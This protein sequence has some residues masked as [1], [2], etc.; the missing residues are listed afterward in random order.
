MLSGSVETTSKVV[1]ASGTVATGIQAPPSKGWYQP[2]SEFTSYSQVPWYRKR[3]VL[4][5][6]II[7]IVFLPVASLLAFS[8]DVYFTKKGQVVK[9]SKGYRVFIGLFTL[10]MFVLLISGQ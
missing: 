9:F 5:V 7:A 4:F 2:C 8:G 6:C 1:S 10:A 3:W